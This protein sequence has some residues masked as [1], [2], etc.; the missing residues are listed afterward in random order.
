MTH[1]W[2]PPHP[3]TS[4]R[5]LRHRHRRESEGSRDSLANPAAAVRPHYRV[6]HQDS[7][8]LDLECSARATSSYSSGLPAEQLLDV[9]EALQF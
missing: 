2:S 5:R 8:N 3:S 4:R 9:W 7:K 6:T 1:G